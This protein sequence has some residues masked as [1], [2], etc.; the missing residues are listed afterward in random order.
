MPS[1]SVF[2]S[3]SLFMEW[4]SFWI[5]HSK[6]VKLPITSRSFQKC[7]LFWRR[8]KRKRKWL[9]SWS[10]RQ[11]SHIA[12]IRKLWHSFS[13]D[14]FSFSWLHG[15]EFWFWNTMYST[16]QLPVNL[17]WAQQ[18]FGIRVKPTWPSIDFDSI[19]Y[20]F[21]CVRIVNR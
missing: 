5:I 20:I 2:T 3:S 9:R 10:R 6:I 11:A 1:Q 7:F 12:G 8:K 14:F 15:H 16:K 21:P 19:K 17:K 13:Y 4:S 18:L